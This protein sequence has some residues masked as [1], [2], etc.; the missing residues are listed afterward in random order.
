MA[1]ITLAVKQGSNVNRFGRRNVAYSWV[2]NARTIRVILVAS[3]E[4]EKMSIPPE[5]EEGRSY[6]NNAY[7]N[8]DS[9]SVGA[10]HT[11]LRGAQ[12]RTIYGLIHHKGSRNASWGFVLTIQPSA[13]SY[14]CLPLFLL[15]PSPTTTNSHLPDACSQ[16][17]V[18]SYT[19]KYASENCPNGELSR[20]WRLIPRSR[21]CSKCPS[22]WRRGR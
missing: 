18:Y 13:A 1:L 5:D 17:N 14:I 22:K 11:Y 16:P 4:D 19:T 6:C 20:A 15:P 2:L 3:K 21:G 8:D 7:V 9:I 12:A 10:K